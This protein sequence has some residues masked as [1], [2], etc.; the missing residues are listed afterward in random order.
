MHT[1]LALVKDAR[2]CNFRV[3]SPAF[4]GCAVCSTS[5]VANAALILSQTVPKMMFFPSPDEI[6]NSS[7]SK[8]VLTLR[9]NVEPQ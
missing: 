5:G 3:E 9:S 7:R 2:L 6:I 4:G 8:V 1:A